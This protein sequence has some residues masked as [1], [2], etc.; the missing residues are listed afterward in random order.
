MKSLLM[1]LMISTLSFAAVAAPGQPIKGESE[2][3]TAVN[4][5]LLR[6]ALTELLNNN[7]VYPLL[8]SEPTQEVIVRIRFHLDEQN[9]IE[10]EGVSGS[11]RR[12]V[13]YV[14]EQLQGVAMDRM[15][16]QPGVAFSSTLRL[17]M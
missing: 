6:N 15:F 14:R 17:T 16:V 12:V 1:M 8:A 11:S 2:A 13:N 10:L 5:E 4:P 7:E 3:A 9:R